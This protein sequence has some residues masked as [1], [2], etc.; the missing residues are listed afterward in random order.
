MKL[1]ENAK[2]FWKWGSMHLMFLSGAFQTAWM[3]LPE[4]AKDML[5]D[6]MGPWIAVALIAAGMMVRP[7]KFGRQ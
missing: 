1:V 2:D 4:D 5:P 3:T 6:W 7:V